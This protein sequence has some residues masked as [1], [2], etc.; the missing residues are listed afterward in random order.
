MKESSYKNYDEL[1]LFLNAKTVAKVLGVS[2]S[3][4][5]ELMH[6]PSL[7]VTVVLSVLMSCRSSN[8]HTYLRTVLALI[9]GNGGKGTGRLTVQRVRTDAQTGFSRSESWQQARSAQREIRGVGVAAHPGRC[10]VKYTPWPKRDPV[11]NYF[12]LPNDWIGRMV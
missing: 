11:K 4:G 9:R 5:Y 6:E 1:P 10:G 8:S 7:V 3:S 12:H 2:P